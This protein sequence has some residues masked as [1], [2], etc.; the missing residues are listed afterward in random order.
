MHKREGSQDR[1]TLTRSIM[2]RINQIPTFLPYYLSRSR[3]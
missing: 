3:C 2:R 1:T